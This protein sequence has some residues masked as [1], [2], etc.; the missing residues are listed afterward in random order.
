[1]LSDAST[2][3]VMRI[4]AALEPHAAFDRR[5]YLRHKV[6]IGGGLAANIRS[7]SPVVVT[8]L[9]TGGCGVEAGIELEP[10]ARVWLKLPG[11]QNLPARVAW[12]NDQRMGLSFDNPLHPAVVQH[13]VESAPQ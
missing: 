7:S 3:C 11:L 1:M 5:R 6:Q 2:E 13:L 10:G 4:T 8:D 12:T 9:S